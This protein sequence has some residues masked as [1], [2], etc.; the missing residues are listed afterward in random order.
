[1][2]H[3]IK[4]SSQYVMCYLIADHLVA[5]YKQKT[6][7]R[8][9][10]THCELC[11][12]WDS[13][14]R[15]LEKTKCEAQDE[16]TSEKS[17]CKHQCIN[18]NGPV[19]N[20]IYNLRKE[21]LKMIDSDKPEATLSHA[22]TTT[23]LQSLKSE[24]SPLLETSLKSNTERQCTRKSNSKE[25]L[26]CEN[27]ADI[28]QDTG[29][30]LFNVF[31]YRQFRTF[32]R[33][34]T[35][36]LIRIIVVI[37]LLYQGL[38][39]IIMSLCEN[40]GLLAVFKANETD[41][42]AALVCRLISFTLRFLLRVVN[43]LCFSLHIPIIASK[44]NI[45][46]VGLSQVQALP[47]MFKVHEKFSSEEEIAELRKSPETVF[48]RSEE[49]TKR[50]IKAIWIP[51]TNAVFI[52]ALLLYLGAFLLCE[53]HTIQGGV[54]NSLGRTILTV[55]LVNVRIH[56][57]IIMESFSVFVSLLLAGIAA[58][59]YYYENAIAKYAT[60]IGANAESL[61]CNV[62]RR[63]A[64]MDFYTILVPLVLTAVALLSFSTGQPFTPM[65]T[66]RL[67]ANKLVDWYF[68]IINLTVLQFLGFSCN[69]MMKSACLCGYV[70]S[71]V[72]VYW[73]EVE[74]SMAPYGSI[75]LLVY[76]VLSAIC[77]NLLYSLCM[78][79]LCHALKTGSLCSYVW[80]VYC[81]FSLFLLTVSLIVTVYR[82]VAHISL[83]IL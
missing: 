22:H 21:D 82:E 76:C 16:Q 42:Y 48:K 83:H 43:P 69:R 28:I 14:D 67:E 15:P 44:P 52:V 63:W 58:N 31:P 40:G 4:Q 41:Q 64:I 32:Y 47:Q 1:M 26:K 37:F 18:Y 72:F 25:N 55:P 66:H 50:R 29:N 71:A 45:P 6:T 68:W 13:T 23:C 33:G 3:Y 34:K 8:E 59:C 36:E 49:M 2:N 17:S 20:H 38:A 74:V 5:N 46:K 80:F 10:L 19:T 60:T 11:A 61:H 70:L 73:L 57:L 77:F 7:S 30:R 65:P 81:V 79:N 54:C 78:C 27:Q 56:F 24:E 35:K 53:S 12:G 62:R 9:C 51:M 75:L 39:V